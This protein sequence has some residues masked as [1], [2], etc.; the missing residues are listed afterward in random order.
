MSIDAPTPLLVALKGYPGSG[1]STVGAALCRE[2]GWPLIDKDG[3]QD[4][5]DRHAVA[6]EAAGYEIALQM[7]RTQLAHGVSV[8]VDSPFWRRTYENTRALA[9]EVGARLVVVECRCDDEVE[10]RR[11]ILARQGAGLLARRTTTWE[12]LQVFRARYDL[13]A[14]VIDVPHLIVDTSRSQTGMVASIRTWL[15]QHVLAPDVGL[16]GSD[17]R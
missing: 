14:Y 4:V 6:N 16:T 8:I 15:E 3:I 13:D 11:R 12:S 9:D 2:L 1:K 5:L 10:W 17:C 7:A